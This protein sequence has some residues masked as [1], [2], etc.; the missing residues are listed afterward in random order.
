[1]TIADTVGAAVHQDHVHQVEGG[2]EDCSLCGP[3]RSTY[4]LPTSP[5]CG[6]V[7]LGEDCGCRPFPGNSIPWNLRVREAA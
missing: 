2:V 5:C 3:M 1:M 4:V 6:E 7:L